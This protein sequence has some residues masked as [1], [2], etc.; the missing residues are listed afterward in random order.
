MKVSI[1]NEYMRLIFVIYE[2]LIT[3]YNHEWLPQRYT[4]FPLHD[5]P[6]RVL[7][8]LGVST[9]ISTESPRN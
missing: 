8:T 1:I 4:A 2:W 5:R 6:L 9:S 3:N 7:T